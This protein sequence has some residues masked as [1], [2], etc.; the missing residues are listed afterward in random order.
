MD[1]AAG[2]LNG[3]EGVSPLIARLGAPRH[4]A[5]CNLS[6]PEPAA[7]QRHEFQHTLSNAVPTRAAPEPTG[8]VAVT[9]ISA[10]ELSP[11]ARAGCGEAD[12]LPSQRQFC[13]D[14]RTWTTSPASTSS[15]AKP[16][17]GAVIVGRSGSRRS[18]PTEVVNA[19]SSASGS[20]TTDGSAYRAVLKD[21]E[22]RR[23]FIIVDCPVGTVGRFDQH[24]EA[25]RPHPGASGC[26]GCALPVTRSRAASRKSG[27]PR[28]RRRS[29][30]TPL[31]ARRAGVARGG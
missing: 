26:R 8:M 21:V 24:E 2:H 13:A 15:P 29:G 5:K 11:H 3:R 17:D 16:L 31:R 19:C 10:R 23:R 30:A 1:G 7:A 25:G 9:P 28:Q 27:R 14:V 6:D 18:T 4:L 20:P 12:R 22:T